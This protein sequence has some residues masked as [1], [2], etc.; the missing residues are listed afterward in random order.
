LA[1]GTGANT[2]MFTLAD[3]LLL[4]PLP[5]PEPNRLVRID[6]VD[7]TDATRTPRGVVGA[8]TSEIR[9]ARVFSGLCGFETPCRVSTSVPKPDKT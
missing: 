8:M 4:R 7:P 3:A 6:G 2:A 5:V 1:L 9:A